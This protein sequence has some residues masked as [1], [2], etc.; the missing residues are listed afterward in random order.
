MPSRRVLVLPDMQIPYHDESAVEVALAIARAWQPDE[1]ILLGDMMDCAPF[2]AHPPMTVAD[3]CHDFLAGEVAPM[4]RIIDTL[5]G[6]KGRPIIYIEGNHEHRIQ[7]WLAAKAGRLGETLFRTFNAEALIRQRVGGDGKSRGERVH[8]KWVPYIPGGFH[9][10]HL[11]APNLVA[12]HG[13]SIAANAAKAH[14]DAARCYSVV[15]G[16]THRRQSLTVRNPINNDVYTAWSPGCLAGL[17]PDYQAHSPNTWAHGVTQ[18]YISERD[19]CDWT[20]FDVAI[21]GGRAILDSGREI[22]I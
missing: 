22:R 20:K 17:V 5:Q 7:R 12:L 18:I 3:A 6:R 16:H 11:I 19:P 21:A 10:Y 15:H 1:V 2:S 8:F 4:N 9:S 13:W 14:L